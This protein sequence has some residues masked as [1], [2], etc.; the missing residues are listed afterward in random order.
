MATTH[1]QAYSLHGFAPRERPANE[2]RRSS[3]ARPISYARPEP[4]ALGEVL[5]VRWGLM[6][7]WEVVAAS[8]VQPPVT[9]TF[10]IGL[11]E[12]GGKVDLEPATSAI[13]GGLTE[14]AADGIYLRNAAGGAYSWVAATA[15]TAY[16]WG[17]GIDEGPPGTINLIP[18]TPTEL[19][20]MTEPAAD[21]NFVRNAAGA[22]YSWEPAAAGTSYTWGIGLDEAAPGSGNIDL[23]AATATVL[24]GVSV[25][26]RSNTQGL[27]LQASG[28][29]TA[30]LATD[31]LAGSIVEP[32]PDGL[33]YV[34][35]RT[36]AGVSSWVAATTASMI[37][38]I[39]IDE[40]TTTPGTIHLQPANFT[41]GEIG[42][43]TSEAQLADAGP[44]AG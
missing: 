25:V 8:T 44:A 42:G 12:A 39:G 31:L 7:G 13:I 33:Q 28:A 27:D 15:G 21:G 6:Q 23:I 41:P 3:L 29:L 24:G 1:A 40:D 34:R 2:P 5:G 17:I 9:Y 19:G 32:L 26:A 35:T 14:P 11:I 22:V 4:R 43:I 10:D 20:G 30:P 18:A 36:V 16:I 37:W 38:G